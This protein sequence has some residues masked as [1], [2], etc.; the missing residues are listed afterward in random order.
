M[1]RM[2]PLSAI[3]C[4]LLSLTMCATARAS[5]PQVEGRY[6]YTCKLEKDP[7]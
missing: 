7:A 1:T 2:I 6:T 3:A 4:F 5:C